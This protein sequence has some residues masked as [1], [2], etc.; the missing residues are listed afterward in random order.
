MA[1]VEEIQPIFSKPQDLRWGSFSFYFCAYQKV[2]RNSLHCYV[3][4]VQPTFDGMTV[5]D[6]DFLYFESEY[7][8]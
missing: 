8:A 3:G 2:M 1:S 5:L 6:R 4:I 7:V